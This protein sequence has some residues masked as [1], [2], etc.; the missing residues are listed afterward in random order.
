MKRNIGGCLASVVFGVSLFAAMSLGGCTSEM[1]DKIL[2]PTVSDMNT[3]NE[4][5]VE[6]RTG[7]HTA[8]AELMT[9]QHSEMTPAVAQ[10]LQLMNEQYLSVSAELKAVTALAKAEGADIDGLT[11]AAVGVFP[12]LAGIGLWLREKT[13]PSRSAGEVEKLKLDASELLKEFNALQ[14]AL[15]VKAGPNETIP[16]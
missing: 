6:H 11:A 5:N 2:Y 1:R 15:A 3:V 13:K 10:A 8:L 14:L 12:G 16:G 4:S 7:L 9:D